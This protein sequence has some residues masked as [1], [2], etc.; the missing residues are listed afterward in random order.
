MQGRETKIERDGEKGD[1]SG[2]DIVIVERNEEKGIVRVEGVERR[3][4]GVEEDWREGRGRRRG[5][6]GRVVRVERGGGRGGEG[7]KERDEGEGSKGGD[8][9]GK[10]KGS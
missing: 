10:V 6:K 5:M 7:K 1:E 2:E 3:E 4:V 9:W 8:C